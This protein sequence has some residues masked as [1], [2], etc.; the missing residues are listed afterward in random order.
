MELQRISLADGQETP[1]VHHFDPAQRQGNTCEF[2]ELSDGGALIG[3]NALKVIQKPL[4]QGGRSTQELE[5]EL[6]IPNVVTETINGVSRSRVVDTD[7]VVIRHIAA[8]SSDK[9]RR[10]NIRVLAANALL[11]ATLGTVIDNAETFTG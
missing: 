11:N 1:V 10:K 7:R 8:G 5:I 9:A 3:R 2:A 6:H 4:G